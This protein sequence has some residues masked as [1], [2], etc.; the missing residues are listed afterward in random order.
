M[1]AIPMILYFLAKIHA[2]RGNIVEAKSYIKKLKNEGT[3]YYLYPLI[4]LKLIVL[5][6]QI[7]E[8]FEQDYNSL[9]ISPGYSATL[10]VD[11]EA[12]ASDEENSDEE[13][14]SSDQATEGQIENSLIDNNAGTG[15]SSVIEWAW[16]VDKNT[17]GFRAEFRPD[18]NMKPPILIQTLS[19]N[20]TENKLLLGEYHPDPDVK[21]KLYL[22]WDNSFSMLRS[23]TIQ[24][25]ISPGNL[26]TSII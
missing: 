8:D 1:G 3:N 16:F 18:D 19:K 4:Y 24:Y 7:G 26:R 23:K 6:Q 12:V 10:V 11:V 2:D 20:D 21:G 9:R 17:V 13:K 5:S 22:T 15:I 14:S 25:K